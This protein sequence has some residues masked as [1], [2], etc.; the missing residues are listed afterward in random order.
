[1]SYLQHVRA[2]TDNSVSSTDEG[3]NIR[4]RAREECWK[5]PFSGKTWPLHSNS[6]K[7]S[8]HTGQNLFEIKLTNISAWVAE[9]LMRKAPMLS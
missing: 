3:Q 6:Q 8:S 2:H 1:M 7:L 4:A 9:G 5:M